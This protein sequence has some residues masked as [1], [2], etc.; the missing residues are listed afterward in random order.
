MQITQIQADAPHVLLVDDEKNVLT[1]LAIGLRR[2]GFAVHEAGSGLEALDIFQ[3]HPCGLVVSDVCM[4][5]MNG[6]TLAAKLRELVPHV[7][8]VLMSAFGF[9]DH[10]QD[11]KEQAYDA[12]LIKP[13]RVFELVRILKDLLKQ[14]S[15][16]HILVLGEPEVGERVRV[17]LDNP[18]Y[19]V[20]TIPSEEQMTSDIEWDRYH[21]VVL[22]ESWLVGSNWRLLNMLERQ[23]PE[24]PLLLLVSQNG[25]RAKRDDTLPNLLTIQKQRFLTDAPWV[26]E[27]VRCLLE[28]NA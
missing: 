2:F 24:C 27:K 20:E 14:E 15:A 17:I 3:S 23:A 28:R 9:D 13:F 21:L 1:S 10:K 6:L 19:R 12:T 8:I 4:A 11:E 7:R 22:S 26:H 16:A 25:D 18:W 5:P